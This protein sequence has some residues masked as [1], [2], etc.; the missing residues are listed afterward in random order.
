MVDLPA[1][2]GPT[3]PTNSS[4][5]NFETDVSEDGR[6]GI[7]SEGNVFELDVASERFGLQRIGLLGGDTVGIEDSAN[8]FGANGGLGDGVGA[9]GKVFDRL[10][11]L[12]EICKVDGKLA[13]GHRVSED[14]SR[15]TPKDD[16]GAEGDGD[17]NNR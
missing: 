3:T 17:G 15:P 14:K 4:A 9:S 6:G 1:P 7:V 11:E 2:V 10:E 5:L 16:G 13:N 12:G 8:A